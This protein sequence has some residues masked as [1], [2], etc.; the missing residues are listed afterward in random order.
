M[1]EPIK[2]YFGEGEAY[3][4]L[5]H[6]KDSNKEEKFL[7]GKVTFANIK[8]ARE[9]LKQYQLDM[10]EFQ[11]KLIRK[12]KNS[13]KVFIKM[14]EDLKDKKKKRKNDLQCCRQSEDILEKIQKDL[15]KLSEQVGF[16][17]QKKEQN[18]LDP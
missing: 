1:D 9:V 7:G 2:S 6:F 4:E 13:E 12:R 3:Y 15:T 14:L 11:A 17:V 16:L 10:E 18:N 5:Y 8:L